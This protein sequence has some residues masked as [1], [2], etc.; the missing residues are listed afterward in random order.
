[1]SEEENG[2]KPAPSQRDID[3]QRE[4]LRQNLNA[5]E[6]TINPSKIVSRVKEKVQDDPA[7]WIA[8]ATGLAV[9]IGGIVTLVIV[10]RR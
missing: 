5:L 2:S 4:A 1:M 9:L 7:P 10:K 8:A 6:D 3:K